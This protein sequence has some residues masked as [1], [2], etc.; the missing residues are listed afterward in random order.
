VV[1]RFDPVPG[2]W[3]T[4]ASASI[5]RKRGLSFAM[6]GCLYAAGGHGAG[7]SVERNDVTSN[8]C[9]WTAVANMIEEQTICCAAACTIRSEDLPEEQD[10]FDSLIAKATT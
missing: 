4:L 3:T 5:K 8:T 10:F 6:G 2:A 9:N 7:T 1:L